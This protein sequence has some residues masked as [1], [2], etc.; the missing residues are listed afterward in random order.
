MGVDSVDRIKKEQAK[1]QKQLNKFSLRELKWVF[2][3]LKKHD[4]SLDDREVSNF[5]K[6][7]YIHLINY[8]IIFYPQFSHVW[9]DIMFK[10]LEYQLNEREFDW[11]KKDTLAIIFLIVLFKRNGIKI[12]EAINTSRQAYDILIDKIDRFDFTYIKDVLIIHGE[13]ERHSSFKKTFLEAIKVKYFTFK[14]DIKF[15]G[16]LK[17]NDKRFLDW[18]AKYKPRTGLQFN[19]LSDIEPYDGEYHLKYAHSV[20]SIWE[21]L[22]QPTTSEVLGKYQ[23]VLVGQKG[24]VSMESM[25]LKDE[26]IKK[27]RNAWNTHNKA[28]RKKDN[29]IKLDRKTLKMLEEI[30]KQQDTPVNETLK[31][32]I[33]ETYIGLGLDKTKMPKARLK[34]NTLDEAEANRQNSNQIWDSEEYVKGTL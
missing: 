22:N 13:S 11:L 6:N 21:F 33:K 17:K 19:L 34:S 32:L 15:L 24:S 14:S 31:S 10:K 9:S 12:D 8:S 2:N 16:W 27:I 20:M 28:L 4:K 29:Q 30:S 1:I 26:F 25:P 3:K 7:D 18:F 5:T 23:G